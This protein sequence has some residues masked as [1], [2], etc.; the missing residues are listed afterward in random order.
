M[1]MKHYQRKAL[2]EMYETI[3]NPLASHKEKRHWVSKITKY[4]RGLAQAGFSVD[5]ETDKIEYL[6][7]KWELE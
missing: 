5:G 2:E 4:I 6:I 3:D 1:L 7:D